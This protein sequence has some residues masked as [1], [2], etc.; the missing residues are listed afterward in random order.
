MSDI[1]PL[2]KIPQ[3]VNIVA[4]AQ[5]RW[6]NLL[7]VASTT[8]EEDY[9]LQNAK[10][11]RL[12]GRAI[13]P[14]L[15]GRSYAR[16]CELI[17]KMYDI[18]LRN[19]QLQRAPY[20][21]EII[22]V[23]V[24][25]MYELRNELV[26]LIVND[27]I[28][29]DAALTQLKLT[30]QDIQIVVP[31]HFPLESRSDNFEQLLQKMWAES[32]KRMTPK[33]KKPRQPE[34]NP[35]TGSR[36][37]VQDAEDE[38][39]TPVP[40]EHTFI[41]PEFIHSLVI[42]RHERF[43]QWYMVDFRG[44][45]TRRKTYFADKIVPAPLEMREKAALL[46]QRVYRVLME[47]KRQR[48]QDKKRAVLVDMLPNPSGKKYDYKQ[49]RDKYYD[50]CRSTRAKIKATYLTELEKENTRL[51]LFKRDRV[52]DDITDEIKEWFKEWFYGYGFFPEYPYDVE[53]G[54]LMV[55]RGI[56]PTIKEKQD[57]DLLFETQ[58]KGKTKEMIKAEKERAKA[59]AKLK[60]E[61]DKIAKKKEAIAA[62]KAKMNP[63]SDPGY[64]V[65]KSAVMEQL[66]ESIRLYRVSWSF[67][68]NMPPETWKET[69]YGYMKPLLTAELMCHMHIE[70]RKIVDELMRLDL[71][72]LI[73]AHQ[74]MYEQMGKGKFPK[75][76]PRKKPK[77]P[78]VPK[79]L[80]VDEKMLKSFEQLFDLG[81]IT[82]PTA[83]L[84]DIYGDMSYAAYDLNIKDP[85]A[86]FPPPGYADVKRRLVL[87]CI[88]GSGMQPGAVRN[89]AVMLLGTPRNG[90]SFLVDVV[91]GEM[92][93]VKINIT[94]EVFSAVIDAPAK[95]L[96]QVF[97]AART[98]QPAV[99]YM[100]NIERV[101]EKKVL[102]E[103]KY[104]Q[105]TV[106][107]AP[108]PKLIK[109]ISENDKIIFIATCSNP[110]G[111]VQAA[112][113]AGM[114]N[115]IILVPQPDYASLQLFFSEKFRR[116]PSMRDD[117]PVQPLAQTC[118]GFGFGTICETYDIIMN[119]Q[120]IV[121]M[122]ITPFGLDEF[123]E[124]LLARGEVTPPDIPSW[125][126]QE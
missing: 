113:M 80:N 13:P 77:V 110:F 39:I 49:E 1:K 70:C 58:T 116:Q 53:G 72:V 96:T 65:Q 54:T 4:E 21:L 115:E 59:D 122:N 42:Q 44:K 52:I 48:L 83:K 89:K 64:E 78:A 60:A 40:S 85:D 105:A 101:F 112:P 34:F 11:L 37:Y 61:A 24:K 10:G 28:Y 107:K 5:R 57:E 14:Q 90:K 75:V 111:T 118:R 36:I 126:Q 50:R 86:T 82:K 84:T 100:K 45:C 66:M 71:K 97:L 91:A 46:V 38:F 9:D 69:V 99:I 117:V 16:Y 12:Q 17:N 30:P 81:L 124:E 19:V 87:S 76:P 18:Y 74:I 125:R 56:Y 79:P 20:I 121:S 108:L 98:F 47:I 27:Y 31:Y 106:L 43:R 67:Y 55:A 2:L 3:Q 123:L 35:I 8:V 6:V 104:L 41:P 95:V 7:E 32:K 25:R 114:F 51:L 88:M 92:N 62:F 119:P 94:P 93:A 22:T 29:V 68:D 23:F 120:R 26:H 102:P 73:A 109:Q 33:V 15:L 103:D 63:F